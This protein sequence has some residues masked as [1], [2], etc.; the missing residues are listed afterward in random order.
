L[1]IVK[2]Q[3]EFFQGLPLLTSVL[4]SV[5]SYVL[6]FNHQRQIVWASNNVLPLTKEKELDAILGMRPGEALSCMHANA[7]EGGCGTSQFCAQCGAAKAVLCSLAGQPGLEECR[8]TRVIHCGP[9]ALDL[10]VSATPLK[11]DGQTY[12]LC[13]LLDISPDKRRRALERIFFHD[14]LNSVG[15]LAGLLGMLE[16]S[17]S[18]DQKPDLQLARECFEDLVEEIQAHKD[19]TSAEND[20]LAVN[21]AL[22]QSGQVVAEVC[23]LYRRHRLATDRILQVDPSLAQVSFTA[24]ARLLRRVLGNLVKNAL[25]AS[26]PGGTVRI[27]CAQ[28]ADKVRF[29]VHNQGVIPRET[30]LQIFNRSF[31]TKGDGR[32]LGTYSVKLLTERYLKG[33]ASFVSNPEQG[34]VFCITLP[35]K[36]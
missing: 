27:T 33:A 9:D 6:I 28:D 5:L 2:R 25:E 21:P 13:S 31:S 19:L 23:G 1:E 26:P 30:Q 16:E 29:E 20:Q 18:P 10:L 8:L 12:S 15:G 3:A 35:L 4:N 24:D 14:I 11:H 7:H 34:T 36:S 17:A 32:G 22:V